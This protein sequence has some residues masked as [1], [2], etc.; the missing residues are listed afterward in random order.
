LCTVQARKLETVDFKAK[1]AIVAEGGV[2][3]GGEYSPF[4]MWEMTKI[5]ISKKRKTKTQPF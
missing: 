4:S 2:G 5:K 1:L 3:E